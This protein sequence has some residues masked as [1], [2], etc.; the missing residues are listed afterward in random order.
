M[1]KTLY[2]HIFSLIV[3]CSMAVFVLPLHGNTQGLPFIASKKTTEDP[4]SFN[5][6]LIETLDTEEEARITEE[7]KKFILDE[8]LFDEGSV[9]SNFDIIDYKSMTLADIV[10]FLRSRNSGLSTY[11]DNETNLSAAEIIYY[12]SQNY[13]INPKYI[14]VLLQKEQSLIETINPT[15]RALD[16][17]TGYGVCD[18]CSKE[19]PSL[20]RYKGFKNQ[21]E[22]A[23][24]RTRHY[25]NNRNQFYFQINNTYLIDGIPVKISNDA[26]RALYIYTPHIHGNLN[27]WKLWNR[28]FYTS[29]P[30]GTILK[31][32]NSP[33]IYRIEQDK[34]R[35]FIN[36]SVFK[37]RYKLSDI[38][39]TSDAEIGKYQ[40]G[41]DIS[42]SPY[43]VI[44]DEFENKYLI[45]EDEIRKI[46]DDKTFAELGYNPEELQL[47]YKSD[48]DAMKQGSDI[49]SS[50]VYATGAL[51]R[52]ASSAKVYYV[53]NNTKHNIQSMQI[54]KNRFEYDTI[55]TVDNNELVSI[56]EGS[57]ILFRDGT[58][59][60][61]ST[62]PDVYIVSNSKLIKIIDES[63][64]IE[65]GYSWN[66][67]ITTT[68]DIISMYQKDDISLVS[69][70]L[71]Q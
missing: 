47:V 8:S 56:P 39:I 5:N 9:I 43:T 57:P 67:I 24:W 55:T 13:H 52:D 70:T 7:G 35:K 41:P 64:F 60:K 20:I 36:L 31:S 18:S 62:S 15:E 65:R 30:D 11:R 66:N 71:W 53:E 17:A 44:T 19:D 3:L 14:L 37:D 59:I 48:I 69:N 68:D 50:S 16:W 34:K 23:T 12:A 49:T 61:S 51:L 25:L 58:L 27:F 33:D 63:A 1:K 38:V 28:Y 6:P 42:L 40:N 22:Y 2:K 54:L 4:V 10:S 21:I 45:L 46:V 26:T 29:Y 32:E